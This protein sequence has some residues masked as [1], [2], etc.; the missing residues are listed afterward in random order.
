MGK[1][2]KPNKTENRKARVI[3]KETGELIGLMNGEEIE[4]LVSDIEVLKEVYDLFC[5]GVSGGTLCNCRMHLSKREGTVA[6]LVGKHIIDCPN[7][8]NVLKRLRE[9]LTHII[10]TDPADFLATILASVNKKY[11]SKE[12]VIEPAEPLRETDCTSEKTNFTMDNHDTSEIIRL[13]RKELANIVEE[14]SKFSVNN[15]EKDTSE[16]EETGGDT[17]TSDEP[18]VLSGSGAYETYDRKH[19]EE[20]AMVRRKPKSIIELFIQYYLFSSLGDYIP[21]SDSVH[22]YDIM[23]LPETKYD[24]RDR[25]NMFGF[26]AFMAA[27]RTWNKKLATAVESDS[28]VLA[29]L[30]PE[31]KPCIAL[32]DPFKTSYHWD[33]EIGETVFHDDERLILLLTFESEEEKKQY[34]DKYIGGMKKNKKTGRFEWKKSRDEKKMRLILAH[35]D[36]V[37]DGFTDLEGRKRRIVHAHIKSTAKQI[38]LFKD[39]DVYEQIFSEE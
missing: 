7:G 26:V 11:L 9:E 4:S 21:G 35:W 36:N 29:A 24:F 3:N 33:D 5:A 27:T 25:A 15:P 37:Y 30:N 12:T 13:S 22:Y 10:D 20:H 14:K 32:E 1:K 28:G 39:Q 19:H 17:N 23:L 31:N 2:G 16:K 38:A 8:S 34:V 18:V 6:Y